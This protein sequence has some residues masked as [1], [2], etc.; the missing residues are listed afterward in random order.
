MHA[1]DGVAWELRNVCKTFG[2][3]I[4]N[5]GVFL[6]LR[7]R[8]VHGLVGKNGSGKSIKT[9]CGVHKGRIFRGSSPAQLDHLLT[10]RTFGI[11]TVFQEFSQHRGAGPNFRRADARDRRRRERGGVSVDQ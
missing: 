11:A 2:P 1:P 4:A 6:V 3:V 7:Q 10:A 8:Q 5:D 9:L